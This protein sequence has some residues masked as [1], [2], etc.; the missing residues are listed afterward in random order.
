M[1]MISTYNDKLRYSIVIDLKNNEK[2]ILIKVKKI[3]QEKLI[4]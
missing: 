1:G 4:K 2:M 3:N